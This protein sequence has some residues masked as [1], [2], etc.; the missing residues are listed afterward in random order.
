MNVFFKELKTYRLSLLFWGV[1][2]FVLILASMAKYATY[3]GAGQSINS[4]I[5][6]FPQ[7]VQAIFGLTGFDLNKASG[8]FGVTFMY[9]ALMVT[10]HAVLLGSGII[11]KEE[12]DKT[13]EFL[14][15]KPISRARILSSKIFAGLIC[16]IVLN[17]VTFAS[18]IYSVNNFSKEASFTDLIMVLMAGLFFLQLMFFFIGVA[19]AA[20]N[21]KPKSSSSISASILLTTFIVT[22]LI[23]INNNLEQLK[24]LTPFKY[25]DARDILASGK[26]DPVYVSISL[27]LILAMITVTYIAYDKRDLSV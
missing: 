16:L 14:M 8:F 6:Q 20:I 10:V 13:S 3:S 12:R 11:S 23:N 9:I 24:Y 7:S 22:F 19:V 2:I 4:L 21:K 1:G 25:F 15:T 27:I 18:S 26:L 5:N 17:I